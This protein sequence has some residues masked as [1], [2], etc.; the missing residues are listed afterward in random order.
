MAAQKPHFQL[1]TLFRGK[2]K[3]A[4]RAKPPLKAETNLVLP[5]T[6][7][8]P[9]GFSPPMLG[10]DLSAT[11]FRGAISILVCISAHNGSLARSLAERRLLAER[12]CLGRCARVGGHLH[13]HGVAL[14]PR[15]P[16]YSAL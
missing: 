13:L 3:V 5:P 1:G 11:S 15:A 6:G 4:L 9:T 2:P 14:Q 8:G 7:L 16:R 10:L 12:E